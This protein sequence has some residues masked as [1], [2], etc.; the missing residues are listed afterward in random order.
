MGSGMGEK[1][2]KFRGSGNLKEVCNSGV[3]ESGGRVTT[4]KSQMPGM[5]N[6]SMTQQG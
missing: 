5:H 4:K 3:W 2:G 6:V 1:W